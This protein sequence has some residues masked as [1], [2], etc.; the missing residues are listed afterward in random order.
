[1]A[2]GSL[3]RKKKKSSATRCERFLQMGRLEKESGSNC[4]TRYVQTY[5]CLIVLNFIILVIFEERGER[6]EFSPSGLSMLM[7]FFPFS[8]STIGVGTKRRSRE[9]RIESHEEQHKNTKRFMDF[10][11]CSYY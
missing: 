9:R 7:E 1:V 3:G 5:A 11:V 2:T 8:F 10:G 6:G 4:S